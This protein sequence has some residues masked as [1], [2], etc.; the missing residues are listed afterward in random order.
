MRRAELGRAGGARRPYRHPQLA[1]ECGCGLGGLVGLGAEQ[2][3][4]REAGRR[5]RREEAASAASP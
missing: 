1:H 4:A 2:E 3:W 5:G